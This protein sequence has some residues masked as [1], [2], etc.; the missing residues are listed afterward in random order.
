M[1]VKPIN[2]LIDGQPAVMAE[3]ELLKLEGGYENDNEVVSWVQYHLPSDGRMVHRSVDMHLKKAL[4]SE[5]TAA[6]IG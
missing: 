3:N 6:A 4:F 1:T 5:A 2:V